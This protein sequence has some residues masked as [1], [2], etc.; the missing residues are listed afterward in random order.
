MTPASRTLFERNL[1]KFRSALAAA[2]ITMILAGAAFASPLKVR[3]EGSKSQVVVVRPDGSS[4]TARA[5]VGDYRIGLTVDLESVK[6]G[7]GRII[8]HVQDKNK[9]PVTDATVNVAL[10]MPHHKHGSKP[11]EL[12]HSSHGRYVGATNRL[13]HRG[14]YRAEVSVA[15][16]GGETVKQ[17]F[18]FR[19]PG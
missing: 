9:K 18:S 11:I 6:L 4:K 16:T 19:R 5:R 15:L 10:S 8:A 12:R 2:G 1:I 17:V 14:L 7:T 13:G 3:T